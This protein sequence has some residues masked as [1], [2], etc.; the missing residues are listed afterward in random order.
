MMDHSLSLSARRSNIFNSSTSD[1][2]KVDF[3]RLRDLH[4][5]VAHKKTRLKPT[6]PGVRRSKVPADYASQVAVP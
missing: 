2:L 4:D 5:A 6:D 3:K 1:G